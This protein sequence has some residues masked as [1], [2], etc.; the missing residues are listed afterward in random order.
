MIIDPQA[1]QLIEQYDLDPHP[2]G[3]Y[4]RRIY[5]SK[6][7]V[8]RPIPDG[9]GSETLRAGSSIYHLLP[10]DEVSK[11]HRLRSDEVW[12][13]C[14][15]HPITLHCFSEAKKP[16]KITLSKEAS[17]DQFQYTVSAGTW[18]GATVEQGYALV[19]CTVFPEFRFED[20]ELADSS[21][22]KRQFPDHH[23]LIDQL[24]P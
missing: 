8:H 24:T 21:T 12:H 22:L 1:Q 11:I 3:G 5:E 15:G 6:L 13:F 7:E 10:S 17:T 16:E 14:H 23:Q 18:F 19:G 20:F 9:S 4:Y 2:E